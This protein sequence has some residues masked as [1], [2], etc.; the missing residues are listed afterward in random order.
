MSDDDRDN[1]DFGPVV[2]FIAVAVALTIL[3]VI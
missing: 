1:R 3:L 2:G